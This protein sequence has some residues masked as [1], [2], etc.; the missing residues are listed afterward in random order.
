MNV[1]SGDANECAIGVKGDDG[2]CTNSLLV[3]KIADALG[4]QQ[5]GNI[6]QVMDKVKEQTNC[7]GERCVLQNAKVRAVVDPTTLKKEINTKLKVLGPSNSVNL[8][9]N[10]NIDNVLTQLVSNPKYN[11][12]YH[13]KFQMIDFHGNSM[14]DPSE[15]GTIDV[16]KDVI[17]A[18]HDC[19]GVVLNTDNRSG[20]GI[21]WFAV[22]CDFRTAGTKQ[23]PYTL[24]YFNSSGNPPLKPVHKWLVDTES[25]I[26]NYVFPSGVNSRVAVIT[27]GS[28]VSHQKGRTECG[29]YSI[30]YIS[31]RVLGHT[32]AEFNGKAIPDALMTKFRKN[33]FTEA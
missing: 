1:V 4:I 9:T 25:Y 22:F 20:N 21:H 3:V 5:K 14:F 7:D 32:V 12:F 27:P 19:F 16:V 17:L 28:T 29:L 30:Y 18:G 8:L 26:N 10:H 24:E 2:V 23:N 6:K 33:I 31:S 13:L 15:L 11:K